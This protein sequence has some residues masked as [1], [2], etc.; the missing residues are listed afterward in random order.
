MPGYLIISLLFGEI[1]VF[2]AE[3]IAFPILVKEHKTFRIVA[4]IF[5][6][7]VVSLIAGGYI[8]TV[9]PV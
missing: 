2:L 9:L 7:N 4:C 5:L 1:L 8:I 3:L 6:A